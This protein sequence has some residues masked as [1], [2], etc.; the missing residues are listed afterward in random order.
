MTIYEKEFTPDEDGAEER[1]E[2]AYETE[3]DDKMDSKEEVEVKWKVTHKFYIAGVQHHNMHKVLS[4]LKEGLY[5]QLVPEPTNKYDPNAVRIIFLTA[6]KDVMLGYV[7]KKFSSE[8]SAA[9]EIGK[10]VECIIVTFNKQSK[11]W[12]MCEVEIVEEVEDA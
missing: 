4:I 9:I 2:K 11:P 6:K 5:L 7:P 10:N 8:V 1:Y 12:E 3:T